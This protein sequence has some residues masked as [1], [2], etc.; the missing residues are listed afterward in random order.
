MPVH[1]GA[2]APAPAGKNS[3]A[4][5]AAVA[6][7]IRARRKTALELHDP[8]VGHGDLRYRVDKLW[9]KADPAKLPVRDCHEM[10]QSAS[11]TAPTSTRTSFTEKDDAIHRPIGSFPTEF[12]PRAKSSMN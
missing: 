10:V 4:T 8:V 11:G 3:N 12:L 7:P 6:R 5:N 1:E 2:C 9:C